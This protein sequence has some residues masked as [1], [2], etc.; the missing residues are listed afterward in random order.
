MFQIYFFSHREKIK[1]I[2]SGVFLLSLFDNIKFMISDKFRRQLSREVQLWQRENLIDAGQYERLS[3][4]YQF[5]NLET[6]ARNTFVSILI[7]LGS[8]L[9][10]IGAITF[11]AANW[12]EISRNFKVI[13]LIS[14]F[15]GTNIVA[16]HF[17]RQNEDRKRRLGQGLFILAAL[18]LGANIGLMSQMFHISGSAYELFMAWALGV[19]IMTYSLQITS[20]GI[21]AILLM[22]LGY[23]GFWVEFQSQQITE[24][25]KF[26]FLGQH[27]PLVA[28]IVFIPLAYWCRSSIIFSL[29]C[30]A[31]C[32]ALLGNLQPIN[33]S[34]FSFK[35][36][37]WVLVFAFVLP[38]ALLWSYQDSWWVD[39]P[40]SNQ[41]KNSSIWNLDRAKIPFPI[42]SQRLTYW[43]LGVLF[44]WT[45]FDEFWKMFSRDNNS[46]YYGN[47]T[48]IDW[49]PTVDIIL[50]ALVAIVQWGKLIYR[51]IKSPRQNN[52]QDIIIAIFLSISA[53]VPLW[54]SYNGEIVIVATTI[55]NILL[56]VFAAG[57]IRS[58][59]NR[60]DRVAFW[61]GML[62]LIFR[63]LGWT[64]AYDTE[65]ILKSLIFIG[66]GIAVIL[67]G[68]WFEK[69]LHR[70]HE[71]KT[72]V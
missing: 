10:G 32:S 64:F 54:H 47:F 31:I 53:I 70:L 13:L 27:M 22:G 67:L 8:I 2:C 43:Y 25:T 30:I 20:L 49:F 29:A 61:G 9:I 34:F 37:A 23:W 40:I 18:F 69:H 51:A 45:S 42:I 52:S 16:F 21:V 71:N 5:D 28:T 6:I 4:R 7:G 63:I 60:G 65:L 39:L 14:S 48:E 58:A 12:Q 35:A 44:L 55:F 57:L 1:K 33:F 24:V 68:L 38:P 72:V 66:C 50:L 36:T 19:L 26:I 62:L 46:S 17:W 3:Q 11:V 56:F 41:R 15:V 59:L